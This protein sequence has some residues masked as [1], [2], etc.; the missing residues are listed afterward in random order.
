MPWRMGVGGPV[1]AWGCLGGWEMQGAAWLHGA[2]S[3]SGMRGM[4]V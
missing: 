3:V 2:L 1:A 4:G